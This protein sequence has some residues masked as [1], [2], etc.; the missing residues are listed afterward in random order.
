MV[1]LEKGVLRTISPIR[2]SL[3]GIP[4]VPV[5]VLVRITKVLYSKALSSPVFAFI[6]IVAFLAGVMLIAVSG[7]IHRCLY[8]SSSVPFIPIV[9]FLV[10]CVPLRYLCLFA[11]IAGSVHPNSCLPRRCCARH[12]YFSFSSLVSAFITAVVCVYHQELPLSP[13]EKPAVM[14]L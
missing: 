12:Q 5:V 2:Y 9:A 4:I 10:C 1:C 6:P 14:V 8:S 13:Y 3:A 7:R 11:F